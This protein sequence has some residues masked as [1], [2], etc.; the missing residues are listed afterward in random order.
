MVDTLTNRPKDRPSNS[1]SPRKKF[2][3]DMNIFDEPAEEEI[4]AEP[5]PPPP[6]TFSEA[7]LEAARA[8]GFEKG[9]Q[10]GLQESAQSREER[11]AGL[12]ARIAED[13][14]QLFEAEAAREKLYET[15]ALKLAR[16]IFE[17]L[18]PLYHSQ[19]GFAELKA[20]LGDILQRQEGQAE[21]LIEVSAEQKEGVEEHVAR[22]APAASGKTMFRVEA[23]E[24]L[25]EG[26]CR[27]SWTHGG[28]LYNA[29][30]MAEE[31][32]G[33]LEEALANAPANGHD[34]ESGT[35]EPVPAHS[36]YTDQ[37]STGHDSTDTDKEGP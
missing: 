7:Q 23:S 32:R 30:A 13:A 36:S 24:S 15:E 20:V 29:H 35:P 12:M 19:C 21:I 6:P 4:P 27:L 26:Q 1:A 3:F 18:F 5:P 8:D 14:R 34:K 10:Q 33:I 25:Q 17:R 9:R 37:D 22:I 31:I 2:L 28:A 11:L 16:A